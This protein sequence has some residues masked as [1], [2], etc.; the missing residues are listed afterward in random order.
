M[1]HKNIKNRINV[2]TKAIEDKEKELIK[3]K[4][5]YNNLKINLIEKIQIINLII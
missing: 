3:L 1:L 4:K 5:E 2:N